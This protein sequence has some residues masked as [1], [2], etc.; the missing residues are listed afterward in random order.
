LKIT[1]DANSAGTDVLT[2]NATADDPSADKYLVFWESAEN[3]GV[4]YNTDDDDQSNLVVS[5]AGLRG[6]TA[7]IDYNDSAQ[8]YIIQYDFATI[9]MDATSVGD[10]WNSGEEMT[11]V[12]YDQDLNLNT[13]KDED[14]TV[15][16][17]TLVP[18]LQIGSP[19]SLQT[20]ATV[21]DSASGSSVTIADEN[22]SVTGN[23][24]TSFSKIAGVDLTSGIF[25]IGAS[26]TLLVIDTKITGTQWDTFVGYGGSEFISFDVR[27]LTEDVTSVKVGTSHNNAACVAQT[28]T[29]S[30]NSFNAGSAAGVE[31]V[32]IAPIADSCSQST[33]SIFVT[34]AITGSS[35]TFDSLDTDATFVIDFFSFSDSVN[36]AIYRIELE[37]TGDNT[38]E[39]AVTLEYVMLNQLNADANSITVTAGLLNPTQDDPNVLV[40]LDITDEDSL[41]VNYLDLG[42]DGV[43]TQIADQE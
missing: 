34:M 8:S 4:F 20:D 9:D 41:R 11:V 26:N 17:G 29:A 39:F 33:D 30:T 32:S 14:L 37:E 27:D 23:N 25:A 1:Y 10:E 43:S 13:F 22:S 6:T 28:N 5:S 16:S 42:A 3:S 7:T 38:A 19:L 21:D 12:L 35:T 40:H 15:R 36:H 31:F 24:P 2:N 18:S